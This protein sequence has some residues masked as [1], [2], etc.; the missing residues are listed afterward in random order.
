[1]LDGRANAC[2]SS[3]P[4]CPGQ[5]DQRRHPNMGCPGQLD[6]RRHPNMGCPGQLDQRRH[7]NMGCPGQLDH[8]RQ[9]RHRNGRGVRLRSWEGMHVWLRAGMKICVKTG[10]KT[11]VPAGYVQGTAA[12]QHDAMQGTAAAQHDALQGTAAAHARRRARQHA[13]DGAVGGAAQHDIRVVSRVRGA[14]GGCVNGCRGKRAL[15]WAEAI[16]KG[17]HSAGGV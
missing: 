1:M 3:C 4:G 11:G 6:H 9:P 10:V 13:Q 16:P 12:A 8:R 17:H 7:P 15:W 14:H 5:L 2:W